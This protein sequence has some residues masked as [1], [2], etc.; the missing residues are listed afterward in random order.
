MSAADPRFERRNPPLPKPTTNVY[1]VKFV[2]TLEG[3]IVLNTFYYSDGQ[4][5]L[6]ATPSKLESL[7]QALLAPA[8]LVDV[9][10]TAL[11]G[12]Y[13]MQY[14]L[15][16]CPTSPTLQSLQTPNIQGGLAPTPHLPTEVSTVILRQTAV[17][18]QCGRGRIG[19]PAVPE[20]WVTLSHV[21]T[22]AAYTNVAA[23][24]M[25]T[26][27]NGVDN[28]VPGLYSRKGSHAFPTEG[29]AS[30]IS[31]RATTLLGTI[32]RRKIGRGK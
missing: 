31:T 1:R 30:L 6:S 32:R 25:I 4:P 7:A 13:Q 17:K 11:S 15:I 23:Q 24:M 28:F 29:Y 10:L 26:E 18:G 19:L 8:A 9:Y 14:L 27:V 2:G 22:P 16:D 20:T 5:V 3:Q 21:T 12:G